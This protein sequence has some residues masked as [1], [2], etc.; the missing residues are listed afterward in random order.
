MAKGEKVHVSPTSSSDEYSSCD[1][2]ME[3]IEE[4][5][6]R[7]FD[8]KVYTKIKTLIKKLEKRDICLELQGEIITRETKTL[9]SK[10]L[11]PR[12]E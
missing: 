5:M 8:K 7:K 4:N 3:A 1:E 11:L 2:N 12:K 6:I 10:H 9:H